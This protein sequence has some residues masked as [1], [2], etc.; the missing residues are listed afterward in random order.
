MRKVLAYTALIAGAL[1]L[2]AGVF[3]SLR[4]FGAVPELVFATCWL[5]GLRHGSE[6][7]AVVGFFGGVL[8]DLYLGAPRVGTAALV[9]TLAGL[10]AGRLREVFLH[11]YGAFVPVSTWLGALAASS[12]YAIVG[13]LFG[14]KYSAGNVLVV[15]TYTALSAI[16]WYWVVSK[17]G[18]TVEGR[19]A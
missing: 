15:A 11:P 3:P 2:Q 10:V 4:L 16:P 7:A 6:R 14:I 8:Q 19:P 5:V 18:E 1:L 13:A 17:V 9:F 12:A